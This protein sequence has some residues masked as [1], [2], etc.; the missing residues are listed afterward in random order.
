MVGVT[1]QLSHFQLEGVVEPKGGVVE[2]SAEVLAARV[3]VMGL[4]DGKAA[5][6]ARGCIQDG[7]YLPAVARKVRGSHLASRAP[8]GNRVI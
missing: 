6:E 3:M 2:D 5:L 7:L 8:R 1:V 4:A